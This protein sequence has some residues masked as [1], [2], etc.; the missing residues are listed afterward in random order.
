MSF[1]SAIVMVSLFFSN[2]F[3]EPGNVDG[4]NGVDLRDA[5]IA[6]QVSAGMSPSNVDTAGDVG[7]SMDGLIGIEEAIF[8]LRQLSIGDSLEY[9]GDLGEPE[10]YAD[11]LVS[12]RDT[13]PDTAG[14]FDGFLAQL[15]ESFDWRD[16]NAVTR[17]EDQGYE[18]IRASLN[19]IKRE[20]QGYCGS[21]WA[22]AAVAALE[23]KILIAGGPEL[24]LSEQQQVSCNTENYGCCG[25]FITAATFW[26]NRGPMAESCTDYDDFY[27]GKG[28]CGCWPYRHCSKVSCSELGSCEELSYRVKN[29]HS[30]NLS[31]ADEAKV[32]I[33]SYGPGVFRY[34]VYDDF[35]TFWENGTAEEV[36]VQSS[37]RRIGGHG[38]SIIGYDDQKN[39]WLCKNSWGETGPNGDGTFWIA[40]TGHK[41]DLRFRM[42]N[43]SISGVEACEYDIYPSGQSFGASGGTGGINVTATTGCEWTATADTAWITITSGGS[44]TGD[45]TLEYSVDSNSD[46]SSRS[47]SITAAGKTFTITQAGQSCEFSISP[48]NQSF[49]AAGGTGNVTVTATDGCQ[50]NA[51]SNETWITIVSGT[52]KIGSGV[53]NYEVASNFASNTRTGT[54]TI[55]GQTFSI[56]QNGMTCTYG[57]SPTTQ[58]V[59]A[60]GESGEVSVSAADGCGWTANSNDSWISVTSGSNGDGN[61]TVSYSVS[62]NSTIDP[63]TGTITIAGKTFTISQAGQSCSYSISPTS[64]SYNRTGGT[65]TISVVAPGGC[66]WTVT[67]SLDW[68]TITSGNSADGDGTVSYSVSEN[69]GDDSRTGSLTI[70]GQTFTITQ[71]GSASSYSHPIPDTGQDRCYDTDGIEIDCEG[72]GQDG[73]YSI[74]PPSYTKL[75]SNGNPLPDSADSWAMVRDDVTGLIWEAKD[76]Y[77]DD[78]TYKWYDPDPTTNGGHP[79]SENEPN[80]LGFITEKNTSQYGGYSDW[81]LPTLWELRTIV[82]YGKIRLLID[83]TYFPYTFTTHPGIYMTSIT[84]INNAYNYW[85]LDFEDGLDTRIAQKGHGSFIRAV[86]GGMAR[87]LDGWIINGDGTV[88]DPQTGLMWEMKTDDGGDRDRDNRYT[89]QEA[90]DYCNNL[91]LGGHSDWRLPDINELA[92]LL[93]LRKYSPP[94]NTAFFPKTKEDPYWSSTTCAHPTYNAWSMSFHRHTG[95]K[96]KTKATDTNGYVRA[97]RGG[98]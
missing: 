16:Y 84:N 52:S 18:K 74:N 20:N 60:S 17:S 58:S 89:W 61:G 85:A 86:R 34:D 56:T 97:V 37:P 54:M 75:D 88:T 22:F 23:S 9:I 43:F 95:V 82:N 67:E 93:D 48:E 21:C 65:G 42:S 13:F 94:I 77:E 49:E 53:V 79:G 73:D 24:N 10:N 1:L 7:S 27:T 12:F 51:E 36:Y 63:K 31:N 46:T 41:N 6:L 62:P 29:Y 38:V 28:Y 70:E 69:P 26:E 87:S 14:S 96:Q 19:R 25:G 2:A 92:S 80:S 90:L 11:T 35:L 44:G 91:T 5:V 68:V 40:Y 47:G 64:T 4:Q 50:W 55:A 66:T 45:G 76:G 57:I 15:P 81:R 33:R 3:A 72:T 32:S 83:I 30:V 59:S 71:S 98:Q 78:N 8:V 39:A